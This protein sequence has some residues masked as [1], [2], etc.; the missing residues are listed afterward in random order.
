MLT[1]ITQLNF[2]DL[3]TRHFNAQFY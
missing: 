1:N 3:K 2:A